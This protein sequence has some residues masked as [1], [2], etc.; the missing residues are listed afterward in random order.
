MFEDMATINEVNMFD[1]L[2]MFNGISDLKINKKRSSWMNWLACTNVQRESIIGLLSFW[3][4]GAR[5]CEESG[6]NSS[7]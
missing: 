6:L 2:R 4:A 3:A 7:T 5:Q 1:I